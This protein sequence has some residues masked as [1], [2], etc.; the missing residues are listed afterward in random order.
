MLLCEVT[1]SERGWHA[2]VT[3]FADGHY[4][5]WVIDSNDRKWGKIRRIGWVPHIYDPNSDT[6]ARQWEVEAGLFVK[7][8]LKRRICARMAWVQEHIRETT[9]VKTFTKDC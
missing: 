9:A 8:R 2:E 3:E 6:R 5:F 1:V 7:W 4:E